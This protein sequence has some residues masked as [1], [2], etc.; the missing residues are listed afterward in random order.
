MFNLR[1]VL[2]LDGS[3]FVRGMRQVERAT[4][5][6]NR[7]NRTFVDSQ[8]RLRDG[9]G[10]FAGSTATA[11]NSMSRFGRAFT[12]PIRA[13]GNLTSGL[14]G[15]V[16][17]YA[18]VRGAQKAFEETVGAAAKYEQ[19]TV[20]ISAILNDKKLGKQYMELVDK[21]AIDSPIMN[22]Q[23]MLAN[24]KS[25]LTSIGSDMK[26]LE[27]AWSLAERMAAIDPMQG[28]EG[29]VFSLREMFSGDAI[30]MVRR[31][32]FP[33]AVMNEIKKLDI[34][35]QLDALDEYFNK[36]GMTQKLIDDMGG[37]TL[38]LWAQ[39]QEKWQVLMRDMGAPGLRV[40][41]RFLSN[42]L[43]KLE[44][45]ELDRFQKVGAR[46][47]ENILKGLTSSVTRVY[48]WF[49]ALTLSPEFQSKTTLFGKVMFVIDDIYANF[50]E[51]LSSD[52]G[53]AKIKKMS[54]DV[55]QLA[56]GG[57]I[58]SQD[59]IV[60]AAMQVGKAVGSALVSAANHEFANWMN[61][62]MQDNKLLNALGKVSPLPKLFQGASEIGHNLYNKFNPQKKNGGLDYVRNDG[63][64]YSLHKGEM[65]LTRSE[66]E[67][68]RRNRGGGGVTITGNTF[69]VRQ[70]SDIQK[71]ALELAKLIEA[72]GAQ[73]A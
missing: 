32:E 39:V 20:T 25:F 30:S 69:N 6:A 29:A 47:I 72:E 66:A 40:V 50:I 60:K 16:G 62:K 49:N 43:T 52:G 42:I 33:R 68:Y 36:I 46:W 23:D 55:I 26:Q 71:V 5:R 58:A 41:S 9:M 53:Q 37:T 14:T 28:V 31:F 44:G 70:E 2:R 7:V 24:S 48:E 13:V 67:E 10:R 35:D 12:S 21:F 4:E 56:A 8:G 73:M 38:G 1:A 17:A 27:K 63:D 19:S 15:L 22:S 34:P 64:T 65:I 61:S 18:A 59:A 54:E 57:L 11:T 51:W 3:Q 45:G